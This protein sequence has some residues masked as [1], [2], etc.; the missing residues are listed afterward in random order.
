LL[1]RA[2]LNRGAVPVADASGRL[3][4]PFAPELRPRLEGG[5]AGVAA[6]AAAGDRPPPSATLAAIAARTGGRE[7][8]SEV[9][10]PTLLD[11]GPD[12]RST[13]QPI[14]TQVLL[15]TLGLFLIDV[16]L[17]RINPRT[18]WSRLTALTRGSRPSR[19]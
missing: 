15:I 16:L 12:Q 8:L 14:R 3:A 10:I 9:D 17:R 13:L 1:L 4:I 5:A 6:R 2:T 7:L 11:P 19:G 18:I